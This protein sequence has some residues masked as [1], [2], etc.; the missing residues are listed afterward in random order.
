MLVERLC[1]FFDIVTI[2]RLD[3]EPEIASDLLEML[4]EDSQSP[5]P[6]IVTLSFSMANSN[7]LGVPEKIDFLKRNEQLIMNMLQEREVK[8]QNKLSDGKKMLD[9]IAQKA[10]AAVRDQILSNN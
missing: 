4:I 6:E 2:L 9:K 7:L 10:E 8:F 5:E 1:R 3:D